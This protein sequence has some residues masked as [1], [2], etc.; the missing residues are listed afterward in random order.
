MHIHCQIE[1]P[2][3][4]AEVLSV[5]QDRSQHH[6]WHQGLQGFELLKG[7]EWEVGTQHHLPFKVGRTE[8]MLLE[9]IT[10]N[11][12]P[13]SIKMQV[14]TLGKGINNTMLNRF[15]ELEN[16]NT[17]YEVEVVYTF[18]SRPMKLMATLM[19]RMF[20]KQVQKMLE[21]FKEA[22]LKS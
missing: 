8:F 19:P 22:V 14:D 18:I 21:R 10:H 17:L 13:H 6:L 12:L 20:K 5:F 4:K 3:S 11:D 1:I 15:T 7:K 16:G 2:A 9:T